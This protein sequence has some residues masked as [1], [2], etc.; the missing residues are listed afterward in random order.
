MGLFGFAGLHRFYLGKPLSG[1][2]YFCTFG[3][4]GIGTIL[5]LMRMS[6]MVEAANF[7]FLAGDYPRSAIAPGYLRRK[8]TPER[9]VL[10]VAAKHEGIVTPQLVTLNTSLTLAQAL[11]QLE[12]MKH[13]GHCNKD[14]DENGNDIY[15]FSGLTPGRPLSL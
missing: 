12:N 4:F 8:K 13:H 1:L 15:M 10:E 6:E 7:R 9:Q 11:R 2:A 3:F 5:D 14:V